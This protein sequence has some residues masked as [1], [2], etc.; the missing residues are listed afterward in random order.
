L[1]DHGHRTAEDDGRFAWIRLKKNEKYIKFGR[2]GVYPESFLSYLSR[3]PH[4]PRFKDPYKAQAF[5]AKKWNE[6]TLE[7]DNEAEMIRGER[8]LPS[9]VR[10]TGVRDRVSA[11]RYKNKITSKSKKKEARA[12]AKRSYAWQTAKQFTHW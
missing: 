2:W 5:A 1:Q 6:I 11:S 12:R 7:H 8:P 10:H 4:Y 9:F 3:N